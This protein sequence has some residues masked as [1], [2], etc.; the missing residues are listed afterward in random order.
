MPEMAVE[1]D[2]ASPVGCTARETRPSEDGEHHT[3]APLN[4]RISRFLEEVKHGGL[5]LLLGGGRFLAWLSA[6]VVV[7]GEKRTRAWERDEARP[8][9][10]LYGKPVALGCD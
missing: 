10:C 4:G 9:H 2:P 1:A 8:G 6:R 5:V 3:V 7:V